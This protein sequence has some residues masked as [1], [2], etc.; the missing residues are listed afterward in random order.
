M[1]NAEC[2]EKIKQRFADMGVEHQ[3]PLLKAN[4]YFVASMVPDGIMVDNLGKK[5]MLVWAVFEAAIDLLISKG[6]GVPVKMGN[7]RS[8]VL[9]DD[10]IPLDSIEGYVAQR[11]DGK[12]IGDSVFSRISPIAGI[13]RWTGIVDHEP[14]FLIFNGCSN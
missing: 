10:K 7:G 4:K 14:K 11:I 13:L 1:K 3:I 12:M 2:I 9:G 5:P 8:G 6:V